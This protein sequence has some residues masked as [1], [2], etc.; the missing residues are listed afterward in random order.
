[1]ISFEVTS[2]NL[3]VTDELIDSF[4]GFVVICDM[5]LYNNYF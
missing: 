1:M 3:V 5:L 2:E 4:S